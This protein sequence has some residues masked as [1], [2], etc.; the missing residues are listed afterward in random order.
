V[1]GGYAYDFD[2]GTTDVAMAKY[3][4]DGSLDANFGTGGMVVSNL[5]M[6]DE[7]IRALTMDGDGNIIAAGNGGGDFMVARYSSSGSSIQQLWQRRQGVR[8]FRRRL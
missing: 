8:G 6:D 3:N 4:S 1:V 5:G 7:T 2:S